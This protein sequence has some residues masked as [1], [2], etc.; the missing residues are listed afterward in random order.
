MLCFGSVTYKNFN[1]DL[2]NVANVVQHSQ[3]QNVR[4]QV[5]RNGQVIHLEVLYAVEGGSLLLR[6]FVPPPP[7]YL[8]LGYFSVN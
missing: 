4:V 2:K 5:Y 7:D 3:N 6:V 1:N 8:C